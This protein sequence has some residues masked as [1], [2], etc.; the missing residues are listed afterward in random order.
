MQ[1]EAGVDAG[2]HFAGVNTWLLIRYLR[3]FGG[4]NGTERLLHEA[5][6]TRSADE[7][8]DLATWSSYEQFR[9]LLETTATEFG[10]GKTLTRAAGGGLAEVALTTPHGFILSP[11]RTKTD[12]FFIS[13]MRRT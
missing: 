7:L 2:C 4:P 5:G 11:R 12:G 10:G 6:E 9:G 3:E 8:F 13:V 1:P